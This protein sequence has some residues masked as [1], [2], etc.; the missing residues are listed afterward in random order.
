MDFSNTTISIREF[1]RQLECDEKTIRHAIKGN[2]LKG[3]KPRIVK[4]VHYDENGKPSIIP[5]IAAK[6]MQATVNLKRGTKNTKFIDNLKVKPKV[7]KPAIVF[8]LPE[9]DNNF[10]D[11]EIENELFEDD[12]N[13]SNIE[14][15]RRLAVFKAKIAKLDYEVKVNN[16]V[17]KN[18]IYKS[19]YAA[20][21]EVRTAVLTVPDKYIDLIFSASNRNEAINILTTALYEALETISNSQ[22]KIEDG[23]LGN[24]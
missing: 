12:D 6:E 21:Q 19:L 18:K 9:P 8:Q 15:I 11:D 17:D 24:S 2:P 5:L 1:A 10:P 14:A 22:Q 16:L 4:G 20:G 3:I 23:S 13:I 7:K